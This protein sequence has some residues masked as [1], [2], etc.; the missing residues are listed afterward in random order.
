[1]MR[2]LSPYSTGGRFLLR[3]VLKPN[4]EYSV[5]AIEARDTASLLPEFDGD[6]F[7]LIEQAHSFYSPHM[8]NRI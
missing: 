7:D 5:T 4:G 2:W 6:G 8:Q 1:M 3:H